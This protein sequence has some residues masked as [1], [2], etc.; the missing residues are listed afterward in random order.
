MP[1]T[2][3]GY[4]ARY[5]PDLT[6][7][8]YAQLDALPE[9]YAEWNALINLIS[10]KDMEHFAERHVLH[11]LSIALYWKPRAGQRVIDI[12]TGGGFPGIPLAILFPQVKFLLVDSIGKKIKVVKDIAER[13]GL[14][15]IEARHA[16]AEELRGKYDVALSRAVARLSVLTGYC[17]KT[18]LKVG[19]LYCLKGGDLR[20]EVEEIDEYPSTVYKLENKFD[21]EFF[22][23]KKVVYVM[24]N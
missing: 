8:Q 5:F 23:T 15:N 12:G 13:L 1:N 4:I 3:G 6:E 2:A 22:E 18:R 10:R 11:S 19:E 21:S 20:E 24:F 7:A 16:R 9:L 17:T 14:K